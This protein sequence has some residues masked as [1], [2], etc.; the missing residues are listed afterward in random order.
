MPVSGASAPI[1]VGTKL[2][3]DGEL[4]E[5]VELG[6]SSARASVVLRDGRGK[7]RMAALTEVL[8][9][10][11]GRVLADEA[12]PDSSESNDPATVTLAL[13]SDRHRQVVRERTAHVQE[14]LTGFR[15][16]SAELAEIGEPRQAY[17]PGTALMQR[18]Q[19]KA[20]ELGV[21]VRTLGD[22]VARFRS[23]G[24]AG[25]A[26]GTAAR[27]KNPMGRVDKR[28]S[29]MA[30]DVLAEYQLASRPSRTHV[31]ERTHTRIAIKYGPD[32]VPLPSR[33]AAFRALIELEKRY[34]TFRLS[35]KRNRDIAGRPE[36]AYGKLRP[37]RPGQYLLM[38]STRLDVFALD[39]VTLRW[40]QAEL[41]VAMD[42]YTRC[43]TGVRVT[44]VSTKS[45]DAAAV[46]YQTYRPVPPGANWP[47]EAVWPQHGVP[48]SVLIDIDAIEPAETAA[49]GP[50]IVPETLVVDHGKIY[51]SEH[52]AS[53][54][55]RL[56]ISIQP[57]RIRTGRDKGPIERFF[58]TLR[59]DLLQILPGYKGPDVH[60]RGL[61]VEN[62]AVF[63]LN[64]LESII[65]EWI[66]V[67]YH[68][69]PHSSLV[70]PH[71][72]GLRM[73][74]AQMFEHGI[75]RAGYIEAPRDPD[76][77][78][79]FLKTEW[80]TI[81]HHAV[82]V[83]RRRYNGE[84]LNPYRNTTSP[85]G[86]KAK[87]RWP[88]QIDPDN[89]NH[90]Y[91]RDPETHV[92][93]RLTWEHAAVADMPF[94]EDALEY[95]RR[96]AA[97]KYRY[98]NDRLAVTDLLERWKLGLGTTPAE[99]RI[100]L[101]Q[102]REDNT[103]DKDL[104]AEE[105]P[106]VAHA[107]NASTPPAPDSRQG[108]EAES[109]PDRYPGVHTDPEWGDDDIEDQTDDFEPGGSAEGVAGPEIWEDI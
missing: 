32:V 76:L 18:Y 46:L 101:R 4:M 9:A 7:V 65:R 60:S 30:V 95:A 44:P 71:L 38:D 28:W 37:T 105:L 58:R 6:A 61:E 63:Y 19:A 2:V 103:P 45:V 69:R 74:P 43:I 29:E 27:P 93:H 11:R 17:A 35:T 55:Q 66:A 24:P 59:E 31:I 87:G 89:I 26:P 96:L 12:G 48:R 40:V 100:A 16:G 8:G 85:Y 23:D 53:V 15:S 82:E 88:F 52:L 49:S 25:L 3:F 41:T 20:E 51:L 50:S 70:D 64:E 75:A 78:Y 81:Q 77:A 42:W 54:C 22:W 107:L 56:G 99:R 68:R 21:T 102:S 67:A 86:G 57:A 5:I 83:D 79:E 33:S 91:F 109:P 92:W 34:P 10:R 13:L 80:R 1:G 47:P 62:E 90:I 73:T 84:A 104:A 94:S 39:P 98:S 14:I 72:P 106:S 36:Q 108:S 97:K